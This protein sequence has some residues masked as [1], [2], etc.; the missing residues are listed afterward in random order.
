MI[1]NLFTPEDIKT[2]VAPLEHW[3]QAICDQLNKKLE[4]LMS[5][6]PVVYGN[7][8]RHNWA[9]AKWHDHT[10][11]ARLAFIQPIKECEHRPLITKVKDGIARKATY[12]E[13]PECADCGVELKA[14]WE[15]V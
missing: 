12:A 1:K 2:P 7:P 13:I 14:K 5:E 9:Y 10:H 3:K 15:A 8:G 6:W 4:K 11:T